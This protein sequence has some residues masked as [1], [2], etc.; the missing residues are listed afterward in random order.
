MDEKQEL[1]NIYVLLNDIGNIKIGITTNFKQRLQSL[2]GSNGG[3]NKIVHYYCSPTT[4]LYT[5][6]RVMH[7]KYNAYRIKGTEWFYDKTL[8]YEDVVNELKNIF[9]TDE[10]RI[11]NELRKQLCEKHKL[12]ISE[13]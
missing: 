13:A 5:L 12:H 7:L 11:C 2:S 8:K 4:Y 9:T 1:Y 6:E 3:G 10:Y